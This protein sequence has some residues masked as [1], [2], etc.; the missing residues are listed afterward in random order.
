MKQE[1][2]LSSLDLRARTSPQVK[3]KKFADVLHGWPLSTNAADVSDAVSTHKYWRGETMNACSAADGAI[4][5][6]GWLMRAAIG[7]P[8]Y[9]GANRSTQVRITPEAD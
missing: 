4:H 7:A 8:I 9:S 6:C 2:R 5:F 1:V 3:T